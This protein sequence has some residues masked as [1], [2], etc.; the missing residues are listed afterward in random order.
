MV[1]SLL[2]LWQNINFV[3]IFWFILG[4]RILNRTTGLPARIFDVLILIV[5]SLILGYFVR[6]EFAMLSSVLLLID[7]NF[8]KNQKFEIIFVIIGILGFIVS[9]SLFDSKW[10][11]NPI[12]L[13]YL[14]L[15]I[16]FISLFLITIVTTKELISKCDI[17]K[18]TILTNRVKAAQL[19]VLFSLIIILLLYGDV[20]FSNS[21]PIWC[22]IGGVGAYRIGK[23]IKNLK[24]IS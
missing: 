14:W 9:L 17:T 18:A 13:E 24:K 6:P 20:G 4:A 15:S 11:S 8:D 3:M 16:I 19:F 23:I 10:F 7:F 2:Y 1:F 12:S 22:A 21:Y 5:L